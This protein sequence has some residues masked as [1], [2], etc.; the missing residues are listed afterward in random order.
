MES[1]TNQDPSTKASGWLVRRAKRPDEEQIRAL[2]HAER[3]NPTGLNYPAFHVVSVGPA[4]IGAAQIRRHPDGSRE[5]ASL[6]VAPAFRGMGI[7]RVLINTLLSQERE[8][9]HVI[10]SRK[11]AATYERLGFTRVKA[12]NAPASVRRNLRMGQLVGAMGRLLGRQPLEL[13]V[14]E[15]PP[16]IYRPSPAPAGAGRD[17]LSFNPYQLNGA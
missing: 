16:Q 3:L 12:R 4:I 6:V 1:F 14:L 13:C 17:P 11:C 10:T 5:F 9:L 2:V 7:G 15:R 8:R